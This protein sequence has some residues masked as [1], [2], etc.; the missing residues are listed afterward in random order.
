MTA[1]FN[2]RPLSNS[3][4]LSGKSQGPHALE[5][6][7]R[8]HFKFCKRYLAQSHSKGMQHIRVVQCFRHSLTRRARTDHRPHIRHELM[9]H[10]AA[11]KCFGT[12][13]SEMES[14][15]DDDDPLTLLRKQAGTVKWDSSVSCWFYMYTVLTSYR[16]LCLINAC[17]VL[18]PSYI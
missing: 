12:E 4:T 16:G 3:T 9:L 18:L 17:S 6:H 7:T 13:I 11:C 5:K 10:L 2:N 14:H 1:R 15:V 8:L